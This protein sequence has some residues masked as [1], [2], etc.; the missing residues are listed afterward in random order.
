ML[1]NKM[2]TSKSKNG[3]YWNYRVPPIFGM[4]EVDEIVPFEEFF[5][6]ERLGNK[7][8]YYTQSVTIME[9]IPIENILNVWNG[10]KFA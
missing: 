1:G 5:T 10:S 2:K 4:L 7:T 6:N 9:D 8:I 3:M